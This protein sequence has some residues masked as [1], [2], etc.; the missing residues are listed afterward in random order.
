VCS[1]RSP[2]TFVERSGVCDASEKLHLTARKVVDAS[3][4]IDL[5]AVDKALEDGTALRE[6]LDDVVHIPDRDPALSGNTIGASRS[7][8]VVETE[9][10]S[11]ALLALD[12]IR[13]VAIYRVDCGGEKSP[14]E[15]LMRAFAMIMVNVFTDGSSYVV[16]AQENEAFE[17]LGLD[18]ED[19][20][21]RVCVQVGTLGRQPKWF[22]SR[23]A[24]ETAKLL[25]E[26]RIAVEDELSFAKQEAIAC[27]GEIA[28]D[29]HHPRA[30]WLGTDAG[31]IDASRIEL[32]D[33]KDVVAD[34]PAEGES[35]YGEEVTRGYRVPVSSEKLFP[36]EAALAR[37]CGV[38]AVRS[39]NRLHGR[40]PDVH[41]QMPE[42]I[43][44]PG[45]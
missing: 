5:P 3:H 37:R 42:R 45:V 39:E 4:Q 16:F 41:P 44:D 19:E 11:Q 9:E 8:S 25:G 13:T 10:S 6:E 17:T 20:P 38:H 21:L 32:E 24:K 29:L 2:G 31:D 15:A 12:R 26:E 28:R 43:A 30:V 23:P 36:R 7:R 34:E 22:D 27:I 1:R 33:E 40:A 14:V 18:G 35:F